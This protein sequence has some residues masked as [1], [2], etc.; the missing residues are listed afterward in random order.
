MSKGVFKYH[1]SMLGSWGG[2]K[3]KI[4]YDAYVVMGVVE[5]LEAKCICTRSVSYPPKM[6]FKFLK[7]DLCLWSQQ[8]C[9]DY[10]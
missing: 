2:H 10:A 1:I 4:A 8:I 6:A 5:G 3:T 7:C 9:H